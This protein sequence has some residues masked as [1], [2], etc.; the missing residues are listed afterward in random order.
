[1]SEQELRHKISN[2]RTWKRHSE[3]APHK[4][5]L[6]LLALAKLQNGESELTYEEVRL[7]MKEL[8]CEFGPPRASY[9]PEHPFVRLATDG[10]WE[11]NISVDEKN[12]SDKKLVS[13]QAVGRFRLEVLELLKGNERLIQEIVEHLL[14]DH[15][16]EKDHQKIVEKVG[17]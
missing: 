16:P 5:L 15:F 2:I 6:L 7:K 10:L 3:R 4:P 9:H 17:L 13:K 12:I 14:Q 8:L 11:L 1:M